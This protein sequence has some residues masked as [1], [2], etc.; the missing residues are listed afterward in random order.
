MGYEIVAYSPMRSHE[1]RRAK[2]LRE[3]GIRTVLDGGA[4]NGQYAARLRQLGYGE[5]IISVE[6]IPR[7]FN[8]LKER[9]LRDSRWT[10][11]NAALA[12]E[13]GSLTLNVAPISEV[14]SVLFA[15][16]AVNTEEWR[17]TDTISVPALRVDDLLRDHE[18]HFIKLDLQGYEME[19]LKGAGA[20]LE[21]TV[22]IEVELSTVPLYQGAVL[23]PEMAV[24]LA[25]RGYSL[26]SVE[27]ALVD[28]ASGR[29]LQLDGLFVR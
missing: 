4:N 25:D 12:R 1:L 5:E 9:T 14:S 20:A 18:Y 29:V 19:A 22:A 6:P 7:V 13:R 23:L 2:L 26:F 15:T 10:C 3:R 17:A 27:P 16:G 11:V 8:L 24:Y 28:Y 21:R